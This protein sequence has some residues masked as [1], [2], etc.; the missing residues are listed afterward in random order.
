MDFAKE[1]YPK[2]EKKKKRKKK[3]RHTL[4]HVYLLQMVGLK[5]YFDK[6]ITKLHLLYLPSM[7][8]RFQDDKKV[9]NYFIRE[10]LNFKF[11]VFKNYIQTHEFIDLMVNFI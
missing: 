6:S 5:L 8:R 10:C 2:K 9:D 11:F 4:N 7:L 3:E 1:Y